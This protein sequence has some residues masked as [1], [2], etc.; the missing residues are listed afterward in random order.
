LQRRTS[1]KQREA[2]ILYGAEIHPERSG[3]SHLAVAAEQVGGIV[4]VHRGEYFHRIDFGIGTMRFIFNS[5]DYCCSTGSAGR[6]L[7]WSR[8]G[9]VFSNAREKS[10]VT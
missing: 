4:F 8:V 5:E 7:P 3:N 10:L 9:D 1:K 6:G 2:A